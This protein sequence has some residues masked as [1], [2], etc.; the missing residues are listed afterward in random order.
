MNGNICQETLDM[1][2]WMQENMYV[3]NVET[4]R[5]WMYLFLRWNGGLA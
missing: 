4:I 5:K 3:G 1:Q 2:V